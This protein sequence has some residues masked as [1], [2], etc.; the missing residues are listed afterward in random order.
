MSEKE[1]NSLCGSVKCLPANEVESIPGML[2]DYIMFSINSLCT[3]LSWSL[4][5]KLVIEKTYLLKA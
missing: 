3:H 5:K 1:G 4:L 2:S